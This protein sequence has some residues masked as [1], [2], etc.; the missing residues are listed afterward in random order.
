MKELESVGL[1][2]NKR[3]PNIYFKVCDVSYRAKFSKLIFVV[4]LIAMAFL[5]KKL[6]EFLKILSFYILIFSYL[7]I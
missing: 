3:K 4:D 7:A 6:E 1:R 5:F 2:L